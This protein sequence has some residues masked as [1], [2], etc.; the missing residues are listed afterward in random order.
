MT[1][2]FTFQELID[3]LDGWGAILT[4]D[5]EIA[6]RLSHFGIKP[7]DSVIIESD[8]ETLYVDDAEV[9]GEKIDDV[10]REILEGYPA[11]LIAEGGWHVIT[12]DPNF[13]EAE[14][15]EISYSIKASR[16]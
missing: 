7:H 15:L 9:L 12:D 1:K 2:S 4:D 11:L 14:E 3:A 16:A 5:D 8:P 10:V 6:E 13:E